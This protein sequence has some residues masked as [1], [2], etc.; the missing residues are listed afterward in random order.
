M[1]CNVYRNGERYWT[2]ILDTE[3]YE[4]P[5]STLSGYEVSLTFSDFAALDRVK[6]NAPTGY[7][8]LRKII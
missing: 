2:G 3:Q 6:W 1:R 7:L 5:Y 8:S 4:E